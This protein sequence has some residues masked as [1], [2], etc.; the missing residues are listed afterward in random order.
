MNG[1]DFWGFHFLF[2]A[3]CDTVIIKLQINPG[4]FLT[5]AEIKE[6]GDYM[7][8][9][10]LTEKTLEDHNDVFSDIMNGFLFHG[11]E[12]V[13]QDE[14]AD[15]SVHSQY[16][17][18]DA[19]MHELE[20]DVVKYWKPGNVEVAVCGLENQTGI[21]RNLP[22]R[23]IGYDGA[24][25]RAQLLKKRKRICPVITLVLYYGTDHRWNQPLSIKE[26]MEIPDEL[27][28]YVN[29]YRI[30]VFDIAWLTEDQLRLFKSDFRV[31][32]NFFVKKREK[33]YVP[34]DQTEIQHVDEVL[35]LLSVMSGDDRY[36]QLLSDA[37]RRPKNMCDVAERL[38]Q[39]GIQKGIQ[40]GIQEG[41]TEKGIRVYW[42]MIDRGFSPE[43]AQA[44]SELTDAEVQEAA[45]W[46]RRRKNN[47][48]SAKR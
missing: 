21:E 47:V 4:Y 13:H 5:P 20:R 41:L 32:A 18:D 35:K 16:K 28:F 3:L 26:L 36:A 22:F 33:G 38:E 1:G 8:E 39:R 31:V 44:V 29:D 25:Y 27:D 6:V 17:A 42:N 24:S 10:D 7:G 9:K 11:K 46:R 34:D 19:R 14:L 40:K 43:D 15:I 45:E 2:T 37:E 23:V 48:D 30:H 12:V